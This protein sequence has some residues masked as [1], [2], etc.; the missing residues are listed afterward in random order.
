MQTAAVAVFDKMCSVILLVTETNVPVLLH[1][2]SVHI[3]L[4]IHDTCLVYTFHPL[5]KRLN[6]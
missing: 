5:F 6:D 3:M 4:N 1:Y 2:I